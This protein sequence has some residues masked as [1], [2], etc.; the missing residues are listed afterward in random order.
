MKSIIV[1]AVFCSLAVAEPGYLA[2]LVSY[3]YLGIPLA[4]DGRV[5]DTP[6][7]AQTKAAHLATQAYEAA[8]NTL[9]YAHVPVL[10]RVYT[11]AIT[12]GAPIGVDG[13]VVDTPEVAEAKAAHLAA[14]AL[15]AAKKIGMYPYGAL[16]YSNI[17]Y[18]YRYGYGAP[19]GPDGRVID[20]PEVADAK[21]AHFA[22]HAQ[23]AKDVA[24]V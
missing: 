12:Y 21:A 15:E 5:L 6:E 3:G 4:Y 11:P 7:V 23:A 18:A 9:G 10:T 8:R 24:K 16:A 1:L 2:P 13:R 19:L 14:H 17:P 20:T 22:A